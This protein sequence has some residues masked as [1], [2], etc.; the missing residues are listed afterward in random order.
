M[1]TIKRIALLILLCSLVGTVSGQVVS[2]PVASGTPSPGYKVYAAILTQ[3]GTNAPVASVLANTLGGTVVWSYADT[4][5][6]SASLSSAFPAGK[7]P[8]VNG[9]VSPETS[10]A[11]WTAFRSNDTVVTLKSLDGVGGS[12][13]DNLLTS[14]LIEIR[15]YP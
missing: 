14:T 10:T 13:T 4:G 5:Q 2:G 9:M 12:P 7:V 3:S 15:V 8:T 6:Y 11:V 1:N